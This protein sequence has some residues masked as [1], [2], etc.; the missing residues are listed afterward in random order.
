MAKEKNRLY[1]RWTEEEDEVIREHYPSEGPSCSERIPGRDKSSVASRANKLGLRKYSAWSEEDDLIMREYYPLEGGKVILRLPGKTKNQVRSRAWFLGLQGTYL[2]KKQKRGYWSIEEDT[3][4]RER[5]PKEG[6]GVSGSLPGRTKAAIRLR[7]SALG[8]AVKDNRRGYRVWT[9]NDIKVLK[10]TYPG[11]GS[12][13]V[14]LK[15]G[16]KINKSQINLK[17]AQLGISRNNGNYGNKK[18]TD[19]EIRIL[20]KLYPEQGPKKTEE[21]LKGERSLSSIRS[22]AHEQGLK[23]NRNPLKIKTLRQLRLH[24]TE[25]DIGN[26]VKEFMEEEVKKGKTGNE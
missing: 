26:I 10:E 8:V 9:K 15:L 1:K 18:W 25:K 17:A 14:Y 16:G 11:E 7:A 13:G 22:K 3:V 23:S 20:K 19:E 21:A 2:G 4:I 24:A 6:L 12:P 5:Y